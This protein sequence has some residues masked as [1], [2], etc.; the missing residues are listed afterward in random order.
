M[1]N[2]DSTPIS[3]LDLPAQ[4]RN[5]RLQADTQTMLAE[6]K[7]CLAASE[8]AQQEITGFLHRY[9][10]QTE[11]NPLASRALRNIRDGRSA[12]LR[13]QQRLIELAKR[14][15]PLRSFDPQELQQLHID[16]NLRA[17]AVLI[18]FVAALSLYDNHLAMRT[19]LEDDRLRRLL[20]SPEQGSALGEDE[21]LD[22]LRALNSDEQQLR[23]KQLANTYQHVADTLA[24][25]ND[26]DLDFL[27][28]AVESNVAYRYAKGSLLQQLLPSTSR[29]WGE[30][31]SDAF[32]ELSKSTMGTISELFG[33][34][35]G[36]VEMRKG[37]L[38]QNAALEQHLAQILQPLDLLLE[39]T[40][41]RL[42][43]KFIPGH[44]GH[45]AMWV[46][47][48]AELAELDIFSEPM[49][50]QARFAT[51]EAQVGEGRSVLEA[52]RT[53]VQLSTL[54]EFL[55]V[56]D[57]AILRPQG[58][59]PAEKRASLLRGFRQLGKQYDFNF[60][61]QT[62]DKIACSELPYHVYPDVSWQTEEQLGQHTITPDQV[63]CQ[64]LS[65]DAP[66]QL[67]A[68]CHDGHV[69]DSSEALPLM[70][71]L[72]GEDIA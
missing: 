60:E 28:M 7:L 59:T 47:S 72:L 3:I 5:Q 66:F 54:A 38:W 50:Q 4:E 48:A 44:F 57:L 46:G 64:S 52:L 55:N 8:S 13:L 51:C 71:R 1:S 63:A 65:S 58:L 40:P 10:S 11:A 24:A 49:F 62:L 61:V 39:K 32:D 14:Y 31:I 37:K 69:V 21:T 9:N 6:L 26:P 36:M 2:V 19:V 25:A 43:D 17:K 53:G 34:G 68:F 18:S 20:L 27:Q 56:D 35:I 15:M 23:L 45:V 41:F 70:T 16:R 12:Y 42:T 22:M 29:I 33:N 67:V 30:R